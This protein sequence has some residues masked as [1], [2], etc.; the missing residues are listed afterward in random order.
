V[1]SSDL[2]RQHG[3]QQ[4]ELPGIERPWGTQPQLRT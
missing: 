3:E 1:C 4:D 2:T